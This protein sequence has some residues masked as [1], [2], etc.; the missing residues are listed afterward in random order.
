MFAERLERARKAAGLSM[1]ALASE[2]GLSGNAIKKY[3]H[4]ETMPSS[5]N[6]P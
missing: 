6:L 2:V 3:E 1:S 5:S 4:G